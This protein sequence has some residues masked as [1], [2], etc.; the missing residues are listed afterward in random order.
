[1]TI[2][3][4]CVGS[5]LLWHCKVSVHIHV[6]VHVHVVHV[7]PSLSLV[8]L[9][10]P[11]GS[12]SNLSIHDIN[13][14]HCILQWTSPDGQISYYKVEVEY[15]SD[16]NKTRTATVVLS[17]YTFLRYSFAVSFKVTAV[18]QAGD[19]EPTPVLDYTVP[20]DCKIMGMKNCTVCFQAKFYRDFIIEDYVLVSHT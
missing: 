12:P 5:R 14:T 2:H 19:G 8:P 10:E 7:V 3:T 6:H 1:M 4:Q 11:L 15:F 17:S 20:N 13:E 9:S 16:V 18:N